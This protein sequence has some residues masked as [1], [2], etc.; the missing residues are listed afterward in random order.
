MLAY[1]MNFILHLLMLFIGNFFS[2]ILWRVN[3]L[4]FEDDLIGPFLNFD[5]I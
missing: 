1:Y 4:I 2:I 5:F 3:H